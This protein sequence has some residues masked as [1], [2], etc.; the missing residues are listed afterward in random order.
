MGGANSD[1]PSSMMET[2]KSEELRIAPWERSRGIV[3]VGGGFAAAETALGLRRVFRTGLIALINR[4][5]ALL[6]RPWLPQA[7]VGHRPF[8]ELRVSLRTPMNNAS[9][10]LVQDTAAQADLGSRELILAGGMVVPFGVLVVATGA[11]CDRDVTPGARAHALFPCELSDALALRR[12]LARLREGELTIVLGAQRPGPGV[13]YAGWIARYLSE[14]GLTRSVRLRIVNQT[15][16][17][18]PH[19]GRRGAR[20]IEAFLERHGALIISGKTV[21]NV[22][23]ENITLDDGTTLPSRLTLFFDRLRGA[24]VGAPPALLDPSGF[25]R[26]T[27]AYQSVEAPFV[28]AAGDSAAAPEAAS[29]PKTRAGASLVASAVVDNVA[30]FLKRTPLRALHGVRA[31]ERMLYMPDYGGETVIVTQRGRLLAAGRLPNLVRRILDRRY[32]RRLTSESA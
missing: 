11:T 7:A 19:L 9:V 17:F 6:M 1:Q 21:R 30:A 23:K 27:A 4:D 3:V 22:T 16:E 24:W 14:H 26:V 32:L 18:L 29:V 12:K 2:E 20:R 10:R 28:F 15:G 8:S 5:A 31:R 25:V 13:E